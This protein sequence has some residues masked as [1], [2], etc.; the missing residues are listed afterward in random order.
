LLNNIINWWEGERSDIDEAISLPMAGDSIK[1]CLIYISRIFAVIIL[2]RLHSISLDKGL[3]NSVQKLLSEIEELDCLIYSAV[4]SLLFLDSDDFNKV[5]DKLRM[6]LNLIEEKT[7]NDSVYGVL[8]WILFCKTCNLIPPPQDFFDELIN[9][10]LG[11]RKPGLRAS[12]DAICVV[13]QR[14][15]EMFSMSHFDSLLLALK[16]LLKETDLPSLQELGNDETIYFD[17]PEYRRLVSQLAYDLYYLFEGQG[18]NIPE[19]LIE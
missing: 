16:Y 1:K 19:I 11:R 17:R 14:Y 5:S 9:R 4:P 15:P 6:A 18:K 3:K 10:I 7:V 2:P 8:N 12:I 13:I